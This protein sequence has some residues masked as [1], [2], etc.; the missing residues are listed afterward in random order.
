MGY[1]NSGLASAELLYKAR[2]IPMSEDQSSFNTSDMGY[3]MFCTV[4]V[5]ILTPAI[6]MFYGGTLKR[7]NIIQILF[8]SYMVTSLVTIQWFLFGYSLAVSPSSSHVMGNFSWGA[9]TNIG[10]GPYFEG[11]TIPSIIYF[12]FSAFFPIAT[13]Q[14][15]VGSIAERSRVLPS[16]IVGLIWCTVVYCPLAYSTWCAN[17]F[18]YNLG[19]LD[20]AGGGPVHIASGAASLAYS[21]FIG[22]RKDW[23]D[24]STKKEYEPANTVITFI[25][26]SIIW[27]S[28]L[29]FNSGTLLAVNTRTGYIMANTQ[30]AASSAMLAFVGVDYAF[31][32]KWSLLA[33]C[34]GAVAGLVNITPSC[35]FYT[36][37]WAFITSLFVGAC[38]RLAYRF[39]EVTQVD[40]TTRSFIIHGFG[41]ILGSICL[42]AFASPYIAGT[43]GVTEIDGGWIYHHWKQMGYQFAGWV[44]CFVWSL[45]ATYIICFI[46]DKIPGLQI[47]ANEELEKVGA[48]F[49]E[50]AE[51]DGTYVDQMYPQFSLTAIQRKMNG[52]PID[53]DYGHDYELGEINNI[54]VVDGVGSS[55]S[56]SDGKKQHSVKVVEV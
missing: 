23:L 51:V 1:A 10:V 3:V 28:W 25:G 35:G 22:K 33:A 20:F 6:G 13:V 44:T 48:D 52:H 47:K 41:G 46:V 29:C 43:D 12:T 55:T 11:G 16:L 27:F 2:D 7:K 18:L 31:T 38:C 49:Y 15:F 45:G 39:N 4:G 50:M 54:Q 8:Q 40:D 9:L 19:A 17:G 30:I 42:G 36:P 56:S 21:F 53:S 37:Y 24:P 14:I 5:M 34:E 32:R 26:V